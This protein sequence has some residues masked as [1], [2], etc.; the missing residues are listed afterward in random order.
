MKKLAKNVLKKMN[1][2]LENKV[3]LR[4]S[5]TCLILSGIMT[6]ITGNLTWLV[7]STPFT[8]PF[9]TILL[10]IV[11][12]LIFFFPYIETRDYLDRHNV[13]NSMARLIAGLVQLGVLFLVYLWYVLKKWD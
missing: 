2:L 13:P 10:L 7:L 9:F 11:I 3:Y 5:F 6:L 4:I 1:A 12:Y 8:V